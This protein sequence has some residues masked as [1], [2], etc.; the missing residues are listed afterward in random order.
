MTQKKATELAMQL[1]DSL[2][3]W[4]PH[5]LFFLAKA[6]AILKWM[7][8]VSES[9]KLSRPRALELVKKIPAME[10]FLMPPDTTS[11]LMVTLAKQKCADE[12]VEVLRY[13]RNKGTPLRANKYLTASHQLYSDS[14][15]SQ[16]LQLFNGL[17]L[18]DRE[19]EP[20]PAYE[21]AMDAA[22]N[23]N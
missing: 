16:A 21:L 1:R 20:P 17:L 13:D 12:C 7:I 9:S 19:I 3:D 15:F 10:G 14:W 23:M 5:I 2:K 11:A 18:N 8:L 22:I 4:K 6:T